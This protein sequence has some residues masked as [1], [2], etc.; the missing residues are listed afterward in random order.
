[1]GILKDKLLAASKLRSK[2]VAIDGIEYVV[3]EVGAGGFADYGALLKKDREKATAQLLSE[4]L[5][6]E[7]GSKLLTPEEAVSVVRSARVSMPLV[8]AIMEVSGFG[9]DEKESDASRTLR[10]SA[11]V[12]DGMAGHRGDEGDDDAAD[13]PR[14]AEVLGAGAVGSVEGQHARGDTREGDPET[15]GKA[16]VEDQLERLSGS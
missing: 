4:C 5:I 9:D 3:R 14:V 7:D 10:L 2:V 13:V 11:G 8:N 12:A 1:M 6:D 15:A 16:E